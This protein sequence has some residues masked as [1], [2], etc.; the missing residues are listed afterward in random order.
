MPLFAAG[1][2]KGLLADPELVVRVFRHSLFVFAGIF[3]ASAFL[4]DALGKA[5]E[6]QQGR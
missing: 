3:L 4:C 2:L 6:R 1:A 5:V